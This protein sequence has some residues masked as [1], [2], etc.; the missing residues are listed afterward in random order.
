MLPIQTRT[1]LPKLRA[2]TRQCASRST[3]CMT[4]HQGTERKLTGNHHLGLEKNDVQ[5][6]FMGKHMG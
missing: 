5:A 2:Q 1:C 4:C 3:A 6:I